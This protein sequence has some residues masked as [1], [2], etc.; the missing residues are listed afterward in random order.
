MSL[1]AGSFG[2]LLVS[3]HELTVGASGA[4]FGLMAAVLI[5]ARARQIPELQRWVA[6]L[7]VF[8]LAFTFLYPDISWGG[9][10]GGL[11]GGALSTLVLQ[12]GD[13]H[14]QRALALASCVAIGVAAFAGGIAVAKS[15]EIQQL[16]AGGETSLSLPGQ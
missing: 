16:P 11:V 5:E 15:S 1:L 3:P 4:V 12:Y 8:N 2:A 10:V 6:G 14:R 13:R 7:I 9:H